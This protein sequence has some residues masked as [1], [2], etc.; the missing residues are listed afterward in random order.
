MSTPVDLAI[1]VLPSRAIEDTV[2]FYS[3]LGFEGGPHP[4]NRDYAIM[5]RQGIEIHFFKHTELD[6]YG[7]SAGCYIRVSEVD[8]FYQT[9]ARQ[10]WPTQGIPRLDPLENKPW[11][12][13]EFAVV[14]PD[15]SLIRIGQI[16]AD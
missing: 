1:P 7:S 6:P 10:A 8:A 3:R 16:L 15:G 5:T 9:C 11:G 12:L 2:A 13:R 14:D 4:F